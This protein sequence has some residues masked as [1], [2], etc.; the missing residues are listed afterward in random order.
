MNGPSIVISLPGHEELGVNIAE[1]L[2]ADKG[3]IAVRNFPDGETYVRGETPCQD[4]DVVLAANLYQPNPILLPLIYCAQAVRELG[5]RR[6]VLA[7]PY[8]PYMRQDARF[9]PGEVV[10]SRIFASL[11]SHYLDGLVTIDPHLHRYTTLGEIYSIP[12]AVV[13]A[14]PAIASWIRK[15][16]SQ[17]VIIGPDSESEQWV[18]EVAAMAGA[19]FLVLSKKRHGDRDVDIEV[20]PLEAWKDH[21][22]VL[23]DDIISTARTMIESVRHLLRADYTAPVCVGVHAVFS[24]DSYASL[25]EAGAEKI[26]TC[27]TIKHTSN[28]IDINTQLAHA[29]LTVMSRVSALREP[30]E[31]Q[32]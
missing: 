21:T 16:V 26:A 14:A 2:G 10:T 5:G 15:N 23:V 18:S 3:T 6:I 32:S 20:P 4:R 24:G 8:L 31:F 17:P 13:H 1:V 30:K 12:T 25:K 9:Q 19:P 29:A 22:P 28:A 11:L 27:N 7:T